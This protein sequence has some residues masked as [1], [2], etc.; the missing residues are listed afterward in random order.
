M[1]KLNILHIVYAKEWGGGETAALSMIKEQLKFGHN[2]IVLLNKK[3]SSLQKHFSVVENLIII[4]FNNMIK[5]VLLLHN[6]IT[7]YDIDIIHTHTGKVIPF[8]ILAKIKTKAKIIVFRHNVLKNKTDFIHKCIYNNI[9]AFI[10]VSK[11]V[12]EIQINSIN[13]VLRNRFYLVYNGIDE[14]AFVMESKKNLGKLVLGYAGRIDESKGIR[15]L[16]EAMILLKDCDVVLKIAGNINNEYAKKL[17]IFTRNYSL[18]KRVEWLGFQNNMEDFY[19]SIDVLIAPSII[20]EAFGLVLCEA[21]YCNCA[22]ISSDSGAQHEIIDNGID[23]ILLKDV[24]Q[25]E[26]SKAVLVYYND[27]E[28]LY[29]IQTNARKK[30]KKLF[31]MKSWMNNMNKIYNDIL[32][33]K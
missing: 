9:D 25:T 10:C 7:K 12:Y 14:N 5:C 31:T 23:G 8:V 28:L 6:I 24:N 32:G 20:P 33:M 15:H 22:V 21:M 19:T 3:S 17:K 26:I 4:D 1:T 13:N 16:L 18:E 11:K 2:V 29:R 30:I 27:R